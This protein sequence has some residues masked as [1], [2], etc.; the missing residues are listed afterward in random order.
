MKWAQ[1]SPFCPRYSTQETVTL[2]NQ[3][4]T[5]VLKM[6]KQVYINGN[7]N[8]HPENS[9]LQVIASQLQDVALKL[10][11]TALQLQVTASQLQVKD[12]RLQ[13]GAVRFLLVALLF[14]V[15]ASKLQVGALQIPVGAS[16]NLPKIT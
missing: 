5:A 4:Q 2:K 1:H 16:L 8:F 9:G 12:L 15:R 14:Q 13:V 11:V 6:K 10:Q 3:T 7:P